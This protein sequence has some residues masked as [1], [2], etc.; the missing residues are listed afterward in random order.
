MT[1]RG[2]IAMLAALVLCGGVLAAGIA[3]RASAQAALPY[4][5]Y[6][7]G[8]KAGQVVEA[9]VGATPVGRATADRAGRWKIQIEPGSASNGDVVTFTLDG[10]STGKSIEFQGGHFPLPPGLALAGSAGAAKPA[11]TAT[12]RPAT[13]ATPRPRPTPTPKAACTL[14]GRPIACAPAAKTA[15]ARR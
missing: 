10:A 6:G 14:A 2:R 4:V 8:L 13:T 3:P 9:L 1:I 5:A 7:S 12:P 11:A 15:T